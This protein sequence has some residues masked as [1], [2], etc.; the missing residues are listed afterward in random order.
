MIRPRSFLIG[1]LLLGCLSTVQAEDKPKI[2]PEIEKLIKLLRDNDVKVKLKALKLLQDK[3]EGAA[4]AATAIGNALLDRSPQVAKAALETLEKV[5]PDLYE[6]VSVLVL[7]SRELNQLKAIRELGLL[8]ERAL[9]TTNLL[10]ARLRSELAKNYYSNFAK[11]YFAALR[12][13]KPDSE[14]IIKLYK[15]IAGPTSRQSEARLEAIEFLVE[16]AGED[17]ARRKQLLPLLKSALEDRYCLI[18]CIKIIGDYADLTKDFVP[19]LKKLKFSSDENVR[20][21]AS[22]ALDKIENR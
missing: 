8:G 5:R 9:P 11:A 16:W 13:I 10:L 6:H 14:E 17:T 21:A 3:G 22:E 18:P 4:D 2:D 15:A 7:D 19:I 12:Q 20:K 1:L